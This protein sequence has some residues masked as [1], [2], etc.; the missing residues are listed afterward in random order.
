MR[1]KC[2][3]KVTGYRAATVSLAAP[4][5]KAGPIHLERVVIDQ[6][7]HAEGSGRLSLTFSAMAAVKR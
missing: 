5:A 3:T 6:H 2:G 4:N 7:R 1:A